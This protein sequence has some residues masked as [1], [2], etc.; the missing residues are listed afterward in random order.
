MNKPS[1]RE[2]WVA[3]LV[4]WH[5]LFAKQAAYSKSTFG[6]LRF[7][8]LDGLAGLDG[9]NVDLGDDWGHCVVAVVVVGVRNKNGGME[10][11]NE[12][13]KCGRRRKEEEKQR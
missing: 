4:L 1:E 2:R 8:D 10:G 12:C 9:V 6:Q 11:E 5:A 13:A 3:V 7:G